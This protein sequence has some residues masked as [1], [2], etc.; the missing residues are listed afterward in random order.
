MY[1]LLPLTALLCC[2]WATAG[3]QEACDYS[4]QFHGVTCVVLADGAVVHE[5]YRRAS[6]ESVHWRLASGTKSFSGVAAAAAVQDKLLTLDDKV[7]DT[8]T[9]WQVDG[10]QDITIRQ[11]LGL[12]SGITTPPPLTAGSRVTPAEAVQQPLAH[13][14]R[15]PGCVWPAAVSVV[16]R[17]DDAQTARRKL[18]GL[19]VPPGVAALGHSAEVSSPASECRHGTRLGW[20]RCRDGARL[21]HIWRVGCATAGNGTATRWSMPPPWPTTSRAP[22][23]TQATG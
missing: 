7:S 2:T 8:L 14:A 10:R 15:Q 20:R 5:R 19:S 13:P 12:I 11:V 6:D 16:C 1:T 23:P 17:A 9:E 22:P 21:G 18:R 4:A 3:P